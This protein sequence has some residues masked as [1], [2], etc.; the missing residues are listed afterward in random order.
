VL[1]GGEDQTN[2]FAAV[3]GDK[4]AMWPFVKFFCHFLCDDNARKKARPGHMAINW[5]SYY[6]DCHKDVKMCCGCTIFILNV[7]TQHPHTAEYL[8]LLFP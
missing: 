3:R 6:A 5:A 4:T 8:H 1:R 7:P 2:P